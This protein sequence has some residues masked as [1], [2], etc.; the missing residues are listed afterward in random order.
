MAVEQLSTLIKMAWG[1][2][3]VWTVYVVDDDGLP[4]DITSATMRFV[5][6]LRYADTDTDAVFVKTVGAGITIVDG[7]GGEA[8]LALDAADTAKLPP[9]RFSRLYYD[10]RTT[11]SARTSQVAFGTLVVRATAGRT[12]P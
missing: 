2:G 1:E 5:G 6:K 11:I 12:A 10:V 8:R 9:S 4:V 7:P 3:A